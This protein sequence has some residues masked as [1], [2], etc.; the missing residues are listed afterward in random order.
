MARPPRELK[1]FAKVNL[2]AG[3]SEK[4]VFRLCARDLS[5]WS[6]TASAGTLEGGD[7]ELAIGAS[8]RD[9]RL[10]TTIAIPAPPLRVRLDEMATLHE[11]LEDP[12][13]AALLHEVMGTDASRRPRGILG[14]DELL[15]LIGNFPIGR[16]AA[17]PGF[18]LDQST[19]RVWCVELL[20]AG[21][22][23]ST[24]NP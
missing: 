10:R 16:L 12:D 20:A 4:V 6:T 22:T 17:F 21:A 8:S 11:W 24:H 13:G 14:N 18:G 23:Y 9:V 15:A 19:R 7:F 5:Y 1:R 2:D 3:E